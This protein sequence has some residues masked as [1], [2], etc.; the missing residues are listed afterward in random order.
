MSDHGGGGEGFHGSG[1]HALVLIGGT[2]LGLLGILA[3]LV[4]W[5]LRVDSILHRNE[6]AG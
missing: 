2:L 4:L 6:Q 1:G 3:W 5:K